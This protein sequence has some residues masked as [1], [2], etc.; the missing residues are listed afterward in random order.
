MAPVSNHAPPP[1]E[2]KTNTCMNY[3]FTCV[4]ATVDPCDS[5]MYIC[6]LYYTN[7]TFHMIIIL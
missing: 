6:T 4:I 2:R 3:H 5:D 7:G 1:F